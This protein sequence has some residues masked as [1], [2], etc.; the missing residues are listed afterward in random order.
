MF[1]RVK[2]ERIQG[3]RVQ[4]LINRVINIILD[5]TQQI[6][7]KLLWT[8]NKL[9]HLFRKIFAISKVNP[10]LIISKG[11]LNN[12]KLTLN[13]ISKIINKINLI[14]KI[15]KIININNSNNNNSANKGPSPII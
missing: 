12:L 15:S 8:L 10:K 2:G 13:L 11:L 9:V 3:R 14:N 6:G 7:N 1:L 4:G 5:I